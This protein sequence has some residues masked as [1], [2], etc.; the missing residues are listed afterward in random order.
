[1]KNITQYKLLTWLMAGGIFCLSTGCK[2]MIEVDLP[3]TTIGREDVF[4]N[5]RTAF[6]AVS[7][8]YRRMMQQNTRITSG[9]FSISFAGAVSADEMQMPANTQSDLNGFYKNDVPTRVRYI[10][11]E[12][13]FHI[14]ECNMAIEGIA[15]SQSMTQ[16]AKTHL[17]GQTHFLRAFFY[18]YAVNLFGDV[19][20]AVT[21]DY[22][23]NNTLTRTPVTMVY[24][25]I[26]SDLK[27][28]AEQISDEYLLNMDTALADRIV[29][30]RYAANAL[31]AR[32][33]LYRKDWRNAAD[34]ATKVIDNPFYH[35]EPDLLNVYLKLSSEAIFQLNSVTPGYN[36]FEATTFYI[37]PGTAPNVINGY[38][39]PALLNVFENGD[40]RMNSWIGRSDVAATSTS[41]TVS[42]YFPYKYK[43]R[44]RPEIIEYLMVLRLAEQYLIRAEARAQLG[45]LTGSAADLNLIRSRAGLAPTTASVKEELLA[46]IAHERQ[47]EL[48]TE[49]GHRWFDL[50]RSGNIDNIMPAVCATKGTVWKTTAQLLPVPIDEILIN[51]N[52]KQNPGY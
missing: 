24:D 33:Y 1:M 5:D 19:P 39:N 41:P 26:T 10:W 45:D 8:I 31:L 46:A 34:E 13:Y 3:P 25:Q 49:W 20:L 16:K 28:A 11:D 17:N 47:V 29:P 9:N 37:P 38:I 50:K 40:K 51:P 30:N 6:A 2:K 48:F 44:E 27:I 4:E 35:L 18:F 32:V 15:D 43:I 14:Y 42:Y 7:S 22:R 52:L 23:I 36:T 12:L 21:S